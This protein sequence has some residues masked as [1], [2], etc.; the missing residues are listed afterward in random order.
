MQL[1]GI[2]SLSYS[3]RDCTEQKKNRVFNK[4]IVRIFFFFSKECIPSVWVYIFLY[5][6]LPD[7]AKVQVSLNSF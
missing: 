1:R 3:F 6:F 7:S 5:F 4:C 2:G